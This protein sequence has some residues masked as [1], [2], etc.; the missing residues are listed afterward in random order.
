MKRASHGLFGSACLKILQH[1]SSRPLFS[2]AILI[3][4]LGETDLVFGVRSGFISISVRVRLQV[5]VC[6]GYDLLHT[7]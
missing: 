7:G 1:G 6:S 2:A 4:K 5:S 3:G